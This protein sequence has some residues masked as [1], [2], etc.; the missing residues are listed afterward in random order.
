[1]VVLRNVNE[2]KAFLE[3]LRNKPF[4]GNLSLRFEGDL[5][6]IRMD[7]AGDDFHCSIT[8]ELSRGLAAYQDEIYRA[9]KF[10]IYGKEGRIQLSAECVA[11]VRCQICR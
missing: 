11:P 6:Y 7:I 3:D 4:D 1:M 10:A 5:E 9:A 2:A 8:G